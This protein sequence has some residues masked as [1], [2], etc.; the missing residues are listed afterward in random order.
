MTFAVPADKKPITIKQPN[1][2]TLTFILQGDERI[3]WASTLDNYS[4]LYN[5]NGNWVYAVID[6]NGDMI[7][8]DILACNKEERSQDEL[9]FLSNVKVNLFYSQ[10][11]VD[12]KLNRFKEEGVQSKETPKKKDAASSTSSTRHQIGNKNMLILLVNFQDKAFNYTWQDFNDKYN[13]E[14]D[15]AYGATG[16]LSEYY[17]DCSHGRLNINFTVVGPY[18][19]SNTS[20]YYSAN[21]TWDRVREM[22]HDAV[23]AADSNV[24]FSNYDSDGDGKVDFVH[25]IYAGTGRNS[26][27]NV[28]EIWPHSWY[29]GDSVIVDG[30]GFRKYSCSNERQSAS[31]INGIGTAAHEIGHDLGLP[32]FYDTDYAGSG[33]QST[34]LGE[35]ELMDAG[36]YNNNANTPPYI[37]SY[38]AYNLGWI[39][40]LITLTDTKDCLLSPLNN[41]NHAYCIDLSS[42]ESLIIE[43][44]KNIKWDLYTPGEGMLIYHLDTTLLEQWW[45]HR[46]N[47]VNIN[48]LDRG[49]FIEPATGTVTDAANNRS[50]FPGIRNI[51][52][53]TS[54]TDASPKLK[55]G[56]I[57][58]SPVT[59]IKYTEDS[60]ISFKFKAAIPQIINK[61]LDNYFPISDNKAMANSQIVYTGLSD[62]IEKGVMWSIDSLN[63]MNYS[64]YLKEFNSQS[65]LLIS[66]VLDSLVAN[67]R[68]YYRPFISNS[69]GYDMGEIRS[70]IAYGNAIFGLNDSEKNN[71]SIKLYPNPTSQ[72]V[73]ILSSG[74]KNAKLIITDIQ[75][76]EV[77]TI[78]K[79][80]SPSTK[81]NISDLSKGIYFVR[82]NN[83]VE[84]LIIN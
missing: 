37:N 79:I 82:I 53:F 15:T 69:Y 18:T 20:A 41:T 64:W 4:L 51:R 49:L 5:K 83:T 75:S 60:L 39:D 21:A 35:W 68:I 22:A 10:K 61:G 6:D 46:S 8:S 52:A 14:G 78:N 42:N 3:S 2:K 32:D 55:D 81:I 67:N 58:D 31:R 71:N 62:I 38:A 19:L 1:G 26:T 84:K 28:D 12:K 7:A 50:T 73:N 70:F 36:S 76:K 25:I 74:L 30:V 77:K 24:D 40:S 65:D 43:Q 57:I 66:T 56:T 63:L 27:G 16:S 11:Q 47:T 29:F 9:A 48:P 45:N 23:M 44:R 33:G 34:T 72:E 13:V 59:H 80:N 17:M 54:L